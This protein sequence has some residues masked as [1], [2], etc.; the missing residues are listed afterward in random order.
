MKESN[1]SKTK[2]GV[3][4]VVTAK[5][6]EMEEKT[7]LVPENNLHFSRRGMLY[8]AVLQ[9]VLLYGIGSW[10]LTGATL[11][12]ILVLNHQVARSITG[13]TV[14]RTAIGEWEWSLVAEALE[15]AGLWTIKEYI[16]L[17]Q[18]TV[19]AQVDC[20]TIYELCMGAERMPVTSRFMY[21][22]DQDVGREV[23]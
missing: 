1:R 14:R 10:V 19:A 4:F 17:R 20:R 5:V 8:K 23:E 22:W 15:A 7:R 11:K 16:Q 2:I 6:G 18:V 13:V 12:V 3:G 9:L 21:W